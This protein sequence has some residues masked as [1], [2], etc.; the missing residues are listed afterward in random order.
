MTAASA[1]LVALAISQRGFCVCRGGIERAVIAD[2]G[3]EVSSLHRGGKMQPGGYTVAGRDDLVSTKRDDRTLW[4]HEYLSAVGGPVRGGT[5]TVLALDSVLSCFGEAVVDAL[6]A[7]ERPN[8]PH[9]RAKDGAK[10]HYSGR[11]DLMLACYP[12]GGAHYGPHVD[13]VDGDGREALDFGRCFTMVYYLND[14]SWDAEAK[15]GALRV[16]LAPAA[17]PARAGRSSRASVANTLEA[18]HDVVDV[19]P[20]GDTLIIFRADQMLHEVRPAFAPRLAVTM[21]LYAGTEA[22]SARERGRTEAQQRASRRG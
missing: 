4:L 15:G 9:G 1:R 20:R 5:E 3:R 2:A 8:E 14:E 16:H 22:Q 21:W 10:L 18:P 11:T 19:A 7:L 6:T 13:N 12:G 17:G